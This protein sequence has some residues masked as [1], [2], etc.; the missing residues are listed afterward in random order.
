M[1]E[2]AAEETYLPVG[3]SRLF[4]RQVGEGPPLVVLHGGPS[5]DH[6]YLVPELDA[7]ADSFRVVYYAQRGRGASYTGEDPADV[8]LASELNDLD[9]VRHHLGTKQLTL[10]GH[11]WGGLLAM[12][13]A[14]SRPERVS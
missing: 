4:V 10:L 11:S 9:L 5:L 8:D 1:A 13:Y 7:L 12:E 14:L 3:S 2:R 6:Q